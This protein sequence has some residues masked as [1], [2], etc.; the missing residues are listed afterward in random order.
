MRLGCTLEQGG[1]EIPT[2]DQGLKGQ[3]SPSC[4]S[5]GRKGAAEISQEE[6]HWDLTSAAVTEPALGS[7]NPQ[8]FALPALPCRQQHLVGAPCNFHILFHSGAA[9]AELDLP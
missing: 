7:T 4:I 9:K 2:G 1:D 3:L 8:C 6:D 5:G